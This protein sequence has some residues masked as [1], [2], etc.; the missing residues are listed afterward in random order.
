MVKVNRGEL[1]VEWKNFHGSKINVLGGRN[2]SP[3]FKLR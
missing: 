1:K 3:V 2:F